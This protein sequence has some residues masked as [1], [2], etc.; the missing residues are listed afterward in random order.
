MPV[1]VYERWMDTES[2]SEADFVWDQ[3]QKSGAFCPL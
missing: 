3:R 2:E 1:S